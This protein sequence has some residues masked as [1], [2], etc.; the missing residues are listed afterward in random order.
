MST[1]SSSP[2]ADGLRAT[3]AEAH[4]RTSRRIDIRGG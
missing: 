3:L 1:S 2:R 4:K